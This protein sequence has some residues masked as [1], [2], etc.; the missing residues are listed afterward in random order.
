MSRFENKVVLITGGGS[1]IG[2]ATAIAFAKEGAKVA[3]CSR[4]DKGKAACEKIWQEGGKAM[5]EQCDVTSSTAQNRLM[6]KIIEKYGRLD[7]AINNAG[8][9]QAPTKL[10]D[11]SE[12]DWN[13]IINTNLNGVWL[14]M[15]VQ[16]PQMIKTGGGVIINISSIAGVKALENISAYAA[17]KAA[18]IMLGRTAALE[19]ASSGIRVNTICPGPVLT[20]MMERF[21]EGDPTFFQE[22]ILNSIPM[23]RIGSPEEIAKAIL[24][25]CSSEASFMTGQSL[26]L[27]GGLTT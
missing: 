22:T 17:S 20:E 26:V 8:L 14:G 21:K 25:L 9:E 15:K 19:Y 16:I 12:E 7:F 4:S 24:W 3:V 10:V 1:G 23:K 11:I 6:K 13:Q 2:L 27:D 5:F 18:V